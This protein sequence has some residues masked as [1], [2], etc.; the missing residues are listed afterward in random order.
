MVGN[1]P[2]RKGLQI[3]R[4]SVTYKDSSR[5]VRALQDVDL[6]LH[7]GEITAI[8][9][10]SGSGKTTLARTLLGA[11]PSSAVVS[12]DEL[13][14]PRR[15]AFVQ[16]EPIASL[17]PL[18]PVGTQIAHVLAARRGTRRRVRGETLRL[19]E[20]LRLLPAEQFFRRYPHQ[21]SGGQAQRITVARAL[22]L[23]AELIVADEPTSQ[24]DL[25]TQAEVA[26][27]LY[28]MTRELNAYTLFITHRLSLVAEI[29]DY[30]VV[31]YEGNVVEQG[32]VI[33]VW[34]APRHDY[35]RTL[36]DEMQ[37]LSG[38]GIAADPKRKDRSTYV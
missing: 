2:T 6:R 30:V 16:Q 14:L 15:I 22:A 1:E 13:H 23:E 33:N 7:P 37:R 25:V 36:L 28:T 4:L 5:S 32:P 17:H 38:D 18:L 29:A 27:L 20:R 19:L 21:L 24:L 11:L 3:R 10:E 35:T 12:Y 34:S 9:G 31:L 26:K 8:V